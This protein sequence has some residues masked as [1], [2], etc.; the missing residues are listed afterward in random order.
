M[1]INQ[2]LPIPAPWLRL[3]SRVARRVRWTF[4]RILS[5]A[6]VEF[7]EKPTGITDSAQKR[8]CGS[9]MT[10]IV[11]NMEPKQA[12]ALGRYKLIPLPLTYS[13]ILRAWS[14]SEAQSR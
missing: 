1:A 11:L 4:T 14:L 6:C 3:W 12:V 9:R 10:T 8:V 5:R 13:L 2:A 7:C